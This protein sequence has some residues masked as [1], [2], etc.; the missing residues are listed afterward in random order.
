MIF[1][2]GTDYLINHLL[3]GQLTGVDGDLSLGVFVG[4]LLQ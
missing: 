3:K 1:F 4:A 2:H